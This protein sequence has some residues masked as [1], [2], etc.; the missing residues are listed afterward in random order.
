MKCKSR[1]I[2]WFNKRTPKGLVWQFWMQDVRTAT[3][4]FLMLSTSHFR[5]NGQPRSLA[6]GLKSHFVGGNSAN[7]H[8]NGAKKKAFSKDGGYATLLA[9]P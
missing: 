9:F 6:R 8:T 1:S 5:V 4:V 3:C 7:G 2:S